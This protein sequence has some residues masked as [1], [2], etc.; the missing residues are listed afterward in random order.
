M[1][2][3]ESMSTQHDTATHHTFFVH[4]FTPVEAGFPLAVQVLDD[5]LSPEVVA[6]L[7]VVATK[8]ELFIGSEP[9][10]RPLVVLGEPRRRA[11]AVIVPMLWNFEHPAGIPLE[12]DI[13]LAAYT[14][15]CAHLH[16]L[17]RVAMPCNTK[18]GSDAA[19]MFGRQAVAVVRHVLN[20]LANLLTMA[21]FVDT[22]ALGGTNDIH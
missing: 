1:A 21:T 9:C 5:V 20:D 13:E 3:D 8:R 10:Q 6:D 11:G 16:L 17:G 18:P 14:E 2:H 4:D 22:Y 15:T 12:A 19:S 7:V